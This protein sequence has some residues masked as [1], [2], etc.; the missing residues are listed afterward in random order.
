MHNSIR[1]MVRDQSVAMIKAHISVRE[2]ARLMGQRQISALFVVGDA[3]EVSGVVTE[4][5]VTR[6]V[7]NGRDAERTRVLE[8]MTKDPI[9]IS[10]EAKPMEALRLM[11]DR[12]FRHLPVV[13]AAGVLIGVL[14]V[15]DLLT[16]VEETTAAAA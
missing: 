6:M 13:D 14:S 5:D 16:L 8:V 3:G 9:A 2:A 10:P 11:R 7:A 12:G 1:D 15:R 4:R